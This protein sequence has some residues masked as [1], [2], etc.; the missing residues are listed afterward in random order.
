MIFNS[1]SLEISGRKF[2][3]AGFNDNFKPM[4]LPLFLPILIAIIIFDGVP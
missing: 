4:A 3:D 1:L 2:W